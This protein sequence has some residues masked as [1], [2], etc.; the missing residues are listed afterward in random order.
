V[1]LG[2]SELVNLHN[3]VEYRVAVEWSRGT[4][5]LWYRVEKRFADILTTSADAALVALL[6]PAMAA[7]EAIYLAGPVSKRLF[8]S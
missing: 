3:D 2:G 8:H 4:D 5:T 1:R 7:G 6:V